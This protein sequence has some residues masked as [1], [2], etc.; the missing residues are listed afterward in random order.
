MAAQRL[1]VC[2]VDVV[3]RAIQCPVP[4]STTSQKRPLHAIHTLL[5]KGV[6]GRGGEGGG[7]VVEGKV[8]ASA[9]QQVLKG[10]YM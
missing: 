9:L 4:Q 6:L 10:I 8:R 3:P 7:W 2:L 5:A 1:E